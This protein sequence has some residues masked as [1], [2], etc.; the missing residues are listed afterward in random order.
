MDGTSFVV[1]ANSL[2]AAFDLCKSFLDL[3]TSSE[4][5]TAA[6]ELLQKLGEAQSSLN[7]ALIEQAAMIQRIHDL[8]NE[9]ARKKAWETE[10]QRYE[11]VEPWRG[12]VAYALKEAM[13]NDEPPH[14]ICTNCYQEGRKSILNPVQRLPHGIY[15]CPNCDLQ[16]E[17]RDRGLPTIQYAK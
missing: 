12:C 11:M 17:S 14:L 13:A 16:L 6:L 7:T 4:V 3:R 9:L 8:E 1:A 5:K 15:G 10:K 2:K